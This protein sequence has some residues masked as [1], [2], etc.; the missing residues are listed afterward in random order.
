VGHL[1]VACVAVGDLSDDYLR[2]VKERE[3][4]GRKEKG[5]EAE[6]REGIE[7][8]RGGKNREGKRRQIN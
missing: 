5:R 8:G 7:K 6:G 1:C 3:G 4:V 2:W